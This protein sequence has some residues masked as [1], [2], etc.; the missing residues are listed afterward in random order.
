ML[1]D[2]TPWVEI[3]DQSASSSQA[4]LR[5]CYDLLIYFIINH[6]RSSRHTVSALWISSLLPRLSNCALSVWVKVFD[7][8]ALA[9]KEPAACSSW[10]AKRLVTWAFLQDFRFTWGWLM[11]FQVWKHFDFALFRCL[12]FQHANMQGHLWRLWGREKDA[13]CSRQQPPW[14]LVDSRTLHNYG[15]SRSMLANIV[16]LIIGKHW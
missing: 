10:N 4:E 3:S 14:F 1:E 12:C 11:V 5:S 8:R 7:C 2:G 16:K 15:Q 9:S 13:S 6:L